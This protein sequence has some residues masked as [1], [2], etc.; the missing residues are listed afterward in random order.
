MTAITGWIICVGLIV[1]IALLASSRQFYNIPR[2]IKTGNTQHTD[3]HWNLEPMAS[4]AIIREIWL[5]G[6]GPDPSE[7]IRSQALGKNRQTR[8]LGWCWCLGTRPWAAGG[9]GRHGCP[10]PMYQGLDSR[11][12]W[13]HEIATDLHRTHPPRQLKD[14]SRITSLIQLQRVINTFIHCLIEVKNTQV[15]DMTLN[16]LI[17]ICL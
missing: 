9:L 16:F 12:P 15:T 17:N 6:L 14:F 5:P 7:T 2:S 3:Y 4:R 10:N 13:T 11:R 1:T 8:K